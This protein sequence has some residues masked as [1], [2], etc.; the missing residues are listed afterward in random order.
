MVHA[1]D[2]QAKAVLAFSSS[3]PIPELGLIGPDSYQDLVAPLL[4]V[5]GNKDIVP[6]FI[7]DPAL[8]LAA[9]EGSRPGE[10]YAWVGK[11]VDHGLSQ[12]DL[13]DPDFAETAA[14]SIIFLKAYVLGDPEAQAELKAVKSSDRAEVR[15][16]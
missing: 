12:H 15:S 10:K 3:G 6:P 4:L 9:F 2:P 7:T 16:R 1:S 14:L 13:Q 5:T 11:S 8:H